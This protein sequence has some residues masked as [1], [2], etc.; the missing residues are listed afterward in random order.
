MSWS[1]SKV[2]FDVEATCSGSRNECLINGYTCENKGIRAFDVAS[3][4]RV[5][6]SFT[7]VTDYKHIPVVFQIL[8]LSNLHDVDVI[9]VIG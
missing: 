2:G 6:H 5:E 8:I 9:I 1:I 7:E 3:S 4:V